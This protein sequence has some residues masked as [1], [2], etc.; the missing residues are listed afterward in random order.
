MTHKTVPVDVADIAK[1]LQ[2]LDLVTLRSADRID[3]QLDRL[4]KVAPLNRPEKRLREIAA[5]MRY[6]VGSGLG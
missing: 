3:E 2:R 1:T 4:V 6:L 5:E